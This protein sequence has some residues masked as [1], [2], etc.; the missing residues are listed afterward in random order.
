MT[1]FIYSPSMHVPFRDKEAL[2]RVRRIKRADITKHWNPE[3][4]ITVKGGA[5]L[6]RG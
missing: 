2:E 4:K 5:K 1:N 3:F 6:R